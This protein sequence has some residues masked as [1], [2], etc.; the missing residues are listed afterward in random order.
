MPDIL[1]CHSVLYIHTKAKKKKKKRVCMLS[2][3]LILH[4]E[5]Q[6]MNIF[7]YHSFLISEILSADFSNFF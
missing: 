6:N 2:F 7:L 3:R 4:K 1:L 5:V